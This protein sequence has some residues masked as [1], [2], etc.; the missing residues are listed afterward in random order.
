MSLL[1][2]ESC[3]HSDTHY[4]KS[5]WI[6]SA[7]AWDLLKSSH[8]L[9]LATMSRWNCSRRATL[10]ASLSSCC[11][12]EKS[13]YTAPFRAIEFV[14]NGTWSG[15]VYSTTLLVVVRKMSRWLETVS[16]FEDSHYLCMRLH[17]EWH[18]EPYP[19]LNIWSKQ[20]LLLYPL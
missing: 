9:D 11:L 2:N 4:I 3:M 13:T 1:S 15:V 14:G 18:A 5:G 6:C 7:W 19:I 8:V 10:L 17:D 20:S 16:I 12:D